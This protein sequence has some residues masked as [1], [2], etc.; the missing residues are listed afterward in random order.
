MDH[1]RCNFDTMAEEETMLEEFVDGEARDL[2][3]AH[4]KVRCVSRSVLEYKFT[5]VP[6][7][8]S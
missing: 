2:E 8:S 4:G 6:C 5:S 1:V 7:K 3:L